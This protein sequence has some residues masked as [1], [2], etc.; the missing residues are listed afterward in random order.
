MASTKLILSRLVRDGR[1]AIRYEGLVAAIKQLTHTRWD[2]ATS[3]WLLFHQA[4][5]DEIHAALIRNS[6][7]YAD[8]RDLLVV[9]DLTTHE[10]AEVGV[11]SPEMLAFVLKCGG[12]PPAKNALGLMGGPQTT[13]PIMR[14]GW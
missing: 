6:G 1:Y 13:P 4:T 7:I 3:A 2:E 11:D 5:A 8:G 14:S 10:F 9:L 12:L